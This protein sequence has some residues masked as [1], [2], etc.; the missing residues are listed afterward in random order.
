MHPYPVAF[1]YIYL[2]FIDDVITVSSN[3]KTT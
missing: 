2:H 1:R 3:N